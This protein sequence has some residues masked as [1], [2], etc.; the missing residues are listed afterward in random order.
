MEQYPVKPGTTIVLPQRELESVEKKP[1]RRKEISIQEQLQSHKQTIRWLLATICVL[2][3]ALL[4]VSGMLLRVLQDQNTSQ[5]IGKNYTTSTTS[6][7][8]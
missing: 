4:F 2:L 8:P 6:T 3:A 7:Q 1:S 5:E